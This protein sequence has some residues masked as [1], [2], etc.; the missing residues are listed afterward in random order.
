MSS[1]TYDGQIKYGELGIKIAEKWGFGVVD[2]Y[3]SMNTQ[4]ESDKNKYLNDYTHPN[5]LGYD[6][7]YI[8]GIENWLYEHIA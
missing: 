1:R 3:K 5:A 8:K 7:F 4:L 2:I 6:T